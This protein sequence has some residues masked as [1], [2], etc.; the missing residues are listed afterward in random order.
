MRKVSLI[1]LFLSGCHTSTV[2]KDI[3]NIDNELDKIEI[4]LT[5]ITINQLEMHRHIH[6]KLKHKK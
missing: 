3:E 5:N 2:N 1:M 6:C 4:R